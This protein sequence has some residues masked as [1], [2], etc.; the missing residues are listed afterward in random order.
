VV[1][2]VEQA[3]VKIQIGL[4]V[5]LVHLVHELSVVA[6]KRWVRW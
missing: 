2:Y 3:V 4:N 5:V 6:W 1:A